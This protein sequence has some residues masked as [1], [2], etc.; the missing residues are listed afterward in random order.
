MNQTVEEDS[1]NEYETTRAIVFVDGNNLYH[2]IKERGWRTWTDVGLLAKRLVGNRKLVHIYYYN[3]PPPGNKPHTDRG[4]AY[5]ARVKN[6]PNLT[7]RASWLQPTRKADE[8]GSYPSY[9]EKGCDTAITADLVSL[10][11]KDEYDVAIIVA[12]DGD[13]APAAKIV[14]DSG[15]S[16]ELVYFT[17][18]KPFVMEPLALMRAFRPG[19]AVP[20]D[21]A[22]PP[23]ANSK[24]IHKKYPKKPHQKYRKNTPR[25]V[26]YQEDDY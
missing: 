26:D 16:V 18:R 23:H 4:N 1:N 5:L 21:V 22:L 11:V 2:C 3:A 17:G 13:Y 25:Q 8:Y 9:H 15:K 7:F 19:W 24:P 12:S 6:T 14:G 20:Y 10:A